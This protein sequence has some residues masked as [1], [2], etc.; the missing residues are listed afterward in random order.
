MP[1]KQ[2]YLPGMEPLTTKAHYDLDSIG[3]ELALAGA[4]T[5]AFMTKDQLHPPMVDDE[6]IWAHGERWHEG[7]V[8]H[9]V[10]AAQDCELQGNERVLDIGC[11]VGGPART[12]VNEF[13]VRVL[14]IT[15]SETQ[16]KTARRINR[17][18]S[19]WEKRIRIL[20]HDCQ[21]PLPE[22][23]PYA[24]FRSKKFDCAWSMNM[25]YH[26]ERKQDA[27]RHAW[28][29]LE[30]EDRLMIDDWMLTPR[31]TESDASLMS[32]IFVAP[33]LIVREAL[34]SLIADQRF[35]IKKVIEL[36]HVGRLWLTKH[37][38]PQFNQH[39]RKR[40]Q[41]QDPLFGKDT[42]DEFAHAIQETAR[43]YTEEKLTYCRIVATKEGAEEPAEDRD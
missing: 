26:V 36:G 42:A 4:G 6:E 21:N 34:I 39:F 37:F 15:I 29:V 35:H 11:G 25:L 24:D 33:H 17:N 5:L 23:L 40:I 10:A 8:L 20:L 31:A 30:N 1:E 2:H 43:L 7:A 28:N 12:L 18:K 16:L 14:G 19:T 32:K 9:T 38:L 41:E 3:S 22:P 13:G 27:F